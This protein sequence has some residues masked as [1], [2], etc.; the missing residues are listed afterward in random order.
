MPTQVFYFLINL[1]H[2]LLIGLELAMFLRAILS[3]FAMASDGVARL[4][5]FFMLITEPIVLP[6]RKIFD[7]FGWGADV[8]LDLPFMAAYMSI[9]L[10]S[11]FL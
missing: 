10:L 7:H 6:F 8:P 3:W 2:F 11:L 4:H 5:G 1:V 9:L